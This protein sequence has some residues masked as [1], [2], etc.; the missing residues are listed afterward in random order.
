[1]ACFGIIDIVVVILIFARAV[2]TSQPSLDAAFHAAYSVFISWVFLLML[3]P[4]F[5]TVPRSESLLRGRWLPGLA[6]ITVGSLLLFFVG[7]FF[8]GAAIE[9]PKR[10]VPEYFF[11]G[12]VLA[13]GVF[14]MGAL[15]VQSGRKRLRDPPLKVEFPRTS[16]Y[17][18]R[19][20]AVTRFIAIFIVSLSV[21][22]SYYVPSYAWLALP[23]GIGLGLVILIAD[24]HFWRR[25]R[26]CSRCGQHVPI[27]S[28]TCPSCGRPFT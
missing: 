28:T 9:I 17:W 13:I 2:A 23:P 10:S 18:E 8:V 22:V 5:V 15:F 4:F 1:M 20:A 14:A 11:E 27:G 7:W 16:A 25:S 21:M 19:R 6:R 26:F 12:I 3:Y 24:R